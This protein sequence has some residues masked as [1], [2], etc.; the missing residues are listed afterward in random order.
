MR[1]TNAPTPATPHLP[2]QLQGNTGHAPQATDHAGMRAAALPVLMLPCCKKRRR[3]PGESSIAATPLSTM[4]LLHDA[5]KAHLMFCLWNVAANGGPSTNKDA[6]P[7]RPL[8]CARTGVVAQ[9]QQLTCW[10]VYC[11]ARTGL[12]CANSS[13]AGTATME[14]TTTRMKR[15]KTCMK[16]CICYFALDFVDLSSCS[17]G[18]VRS[19]A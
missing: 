10:S 7:L 12:K 17:P 5:H 1:A 19:T 4:A 15:W 6:A 3:R 9:T 13:I 8:P 14:A 2:Q 16:R 11:V 18:R